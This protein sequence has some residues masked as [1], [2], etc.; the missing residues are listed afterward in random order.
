MYVV[1]TYISK[2]TDNFIMLNVLIQRHAMSLHLF[3]PFLC[4]SME[5][6]YFCI[7]IGCNFVSIQS[8]SFL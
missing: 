7:E 8:Q 1:N 5:R 6:H 3:R 2:K 4:P